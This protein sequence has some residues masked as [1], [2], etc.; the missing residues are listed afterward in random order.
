M[1]GED[2]LRLQL[3]LQRIGV[4][5]A[6]DLVRLPGPHPDGL[7][8]FYCAR[9]AGGG[10]LRFHRHDLPAA[11]RARLAHVP[12]ERARHDQVGVCAILAAHDPCEGVWIGRSYAVT[13]PFSPRERE[14][15][16]RLDPTVPA[17]RALLANFDA[18]VAGYGW[19]AYA[20]LAG[21]RVV[22]ACVSSREGD[23]AAEAWVQT[24]PA[25]QGRG[26]AR[27]VTATWAACAQAAGKI[28]FYSHS[29][30]NAA[31]AGV[32]R[33]LGLEPYVYD[34]GYL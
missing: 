16:R 31:S 13:A 5:D 9:L 23:R 24:D 10:D 11:L 28:P 14:G 15:V 1:T 3:A 32:A 22:S 6:G 26:Y 20:I 30:D 8:R 33:G 17:E 27:R 4:D 12:W 25:Y 21:G 19:P 34:V 18:E 29:E 2:L 7:P